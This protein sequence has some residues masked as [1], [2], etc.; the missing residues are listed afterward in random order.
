MTGL[1]PGTTTTSSGRNRNA[2]RPTDVAR[3]SLA[4]LRQSGRRPVVRPSL[5]EGADGGIHDVAGRIEVRLADFQVDDALCP[6]A[7]SARGFDQNLKT[8]F[9]VPRRAIPLREF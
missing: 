2:A 6:W 3:Y 5:A 4:E 8:Q 1:P 7:S 9:S